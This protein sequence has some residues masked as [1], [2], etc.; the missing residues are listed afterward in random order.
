MDSS[1]SSAAAAR[2]TTTKSTIQQA[3]LGQQAPRYPPAYGCPALPPAVT[4]NLR[5]RRRKRIHN[6]ANLQSIE[7][8]VVGWRKHDQR[9]KTVFARGCFERVT[10]CHRR[11][12]S[13]KHG[14]YV[15]R[16]LQHNSEHLDRKVF[17][18]E[19]RHVIWRNPG[20]RR[21]DLHIWRL[22][23][24]LQQLPPILQHRLLLLST[25]K[26]MVHKQPDTA[27]RTQRTL[28]SNIKLQPSNVYPR[29]SKRR[30]PDN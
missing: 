23:Q 24:L 3:T 18:A 7:Q 2:P 11:N 22:K 14:Y 16:S 29:W 13:L 26:H 28:R 30:L 8:S 10:L 1:T 17:P 19:R 21:I 20:T 15:R 12:D 9:P 4:K 5:G 6:S 27:D 25:N